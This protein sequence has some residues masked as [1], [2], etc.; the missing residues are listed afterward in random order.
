MSTSWWFSSV[1]GIKVTKLLLLLVICNNFC[2]EIMFIWCDRDK[3]VISMEMTTIYIQVPVYNVHILNN[4]LHVP[5]CTLYIAFIVG[6]NT[7]ICKTM[8]ICHL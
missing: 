8:C 6:S 4:I 5:I 1:L 2:L 3:G 7:G